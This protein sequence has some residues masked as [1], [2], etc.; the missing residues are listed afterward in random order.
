MNALKV[1]RDRLARPGD[2]DRLEWLVTNGIGGYACGTVSGA[3]TRRYHGLLVAALAPPL[4]RTLLLAKL[5]E[6]LWHEGQWVELDVNRWASGATTPGEPVHLESFTLE[7][8]VPVWTW[9]LGSTRL[10]K[11]QAGCV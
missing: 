11:I 7:G 4:P 2:A 10:E 1:G 8:T 9:A 3:L 5:G 6:R